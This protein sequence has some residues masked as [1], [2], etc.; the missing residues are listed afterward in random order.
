MI[1]PTT[2]LSPAAPPSSSTASPL[3]FSNR[4]FVAGVLVV[5]AVVT[6]WPVQHFG[7]IEFDDPENVVNEPHV[8]AG[9][10]RDGLRWAFTSVATGPWMPLSRLSYLLD[11]NWNGLQP[12]AMHVENVVLH[13]AAG[14]LLF[15]WLA[16]AS[17]RPGR[18]AAVAALFVVHPVHVESVAWITERRDVLSISLLMAATW[19]Y[20]R[21]AEAPGAAAGRWAYLAT[22]GLYVGS[23]LAKATGMTFPVL[24]LLLDVWPL[25]RL[26]PGGGGVARRRVL[27]DKVPFAALAVPVAIVAAYGQRAIGASV[28][29][30]AEPLPARVANALVTTVLYAWKLAIPTRLAAYY[31]APQGGWA[32]GDVAAAAAALT[33]AGTAVVLNR[34]RWPYLAVGLGWFVVGL[35]PV[36]GL[37]QAGG[38]SMADRYSYLP[39][40]G[41]T[42][43]AVWAAADAV[44]AA[45]RRPVARDRLAAAVAAA[46]TVTLAVACRV[47]AG[48][49]RDARTLFAH[50]NAVTTDNWFAA[51]QLGLA[52][53]R[54]HDYGAAAKWFGR[55]LALNPGFADAWDGMG[56]CV[57]LVDPAGAVPLYRRAIELQPRSPRPY[58]NLGNALLASGHRDE[59]IAAFRRSLAW[60]P[61]FLY[62][63]R[64]LAAA[65]A[66]P[67]S[68]RP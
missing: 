24:M 49:W 35:L 13:V 2:M 36:T 54:D 23:L 41:L 8:A 32:P 31:V 61:D 4:W 29:L 18:S 58:A 33:A 28:S 42:V 44:A 59:A 26:R 3:P 43:A 46:A 9:L 11:R 56:N 53:A 47:Q 67:I 16:D 63:R 20:V 17:G 6:Y 19:A 51:D 25:R 45:V 34:R 14:I 38:Q 30:A 57:C 7:F 55:A 48:Y 10:T 27:L 64:G 66:A 37:T 60:D 50:A 5:L 52:A 15:L 40:I 62:A 65:T 1:P 39:S 12:G 22:V 68:P 21:Y